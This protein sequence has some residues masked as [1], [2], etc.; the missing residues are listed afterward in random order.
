MSDR[1]LRELERRVH[2]VPGDVTAE[3][4]LLRHR[5]RAGQVSYER[6]HVA[7]LLEHPAAR[8]VVPHAPKSPRPGMSLALVS[9]KSRKLH[10]MR[11]GVA[12]TLCGTWV[13]LE[14]RGGHCVGEP[15]CRMCLRADYWRLSLV[16]ALSEL[17]VKIADLD[18]WLGFRCAVMAV[19]HVMAS[20]LAAHPNHTVAQRFAE[21]ALWG[22]GAL[23]GRPPPPRGEPNAWDPAGLHSEG[24]DAW[25][26]GLGCAALDLYDKVPSLS[27]TLSLLMRPVANWCHNTSDGFKLVA[28]LIDNI[29]TSVAPFALGGEDP[30]VAVAVVYREIA[31]RI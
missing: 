22:S 15:T 8:L 20:Y 18:P 14:M 26:Y 1:A 5:Y 27:N 4:A 17:V 12:H 31:S 23:T 9:L 29:R 11:P 7:A 10:G 28:E 25:I 16:E 24:A 13:P 30:L 3:A 21:Y 19:E 6:L 2:E